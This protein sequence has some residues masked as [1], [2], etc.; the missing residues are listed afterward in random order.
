MWLIILIIIL[1]VLIILIII[2]NKT[3]SFLSHSTGITSA[4]VK[5]LYL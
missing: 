4:A 3:F 1:T 2:N 5:Q